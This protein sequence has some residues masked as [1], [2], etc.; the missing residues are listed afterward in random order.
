MAK[1]KIGAVMV[2]GG[3]I[4]GMQ[5]VLDL[6]E[7]GF[8][9]YLLEKSASIGGRMGQLDKT[10]PTNDCSMCIMGPKLVE[11]GRHLNIEI[12]TLSR[13]E[14][15]TG[16][17]GNFQVKVHQHSRYVDPDKCTGCGDCATVCPVSLPD[18]YNRNLSMRKA[19]YIMYPQSV[20][21]AYSIDKK[22]RPP[23]ISACPAHIN[24]QGYVAMI[25]AC[26]Y[27]EAIEIIMRDAP[28]PGTLGRVCVRFCEQECRRCE[29]DEPVSIKEL[30]RF[31]ADQ[32]DILSLPVPEVTAREE[33]VAIIGSGPSGL[34]A[35]YFLALDGFKPTIFEASKVPGGMLALGIPEYRLPRRILNNEIENIKRLG[36]EIKT[37]TPIGK[38]VTINDLL[39]GGY[40]AVYIAAGAHK[41]MKL[42]IH[43]ENRYENFQQSVPWFRGV[44]LGTIREARGKVVII[45]GGNAAIDAARVSLRLG[46]DEVHI[47]YRRTR[48]EMPADPLEIEDALQEGVQIHALVTPK[49]VIGDN[50]TLKGL[51]CLKNRL[52][53]P[54]SSGR[55]RPVPIDGSEFFIPA[56]QIIAAIGQTVDKSFAADLNEI[57]FTKND[58]L[59][60]NPYTLETTKKGVFAGGDVVTGP[61]TVIEAIAQGKKAAASI[62]S[63]LQDMWMPSFDG[64]DFQEKDY[65]PI[66]SS[67]PKMPRTQIPTLNATERIK[68]FQE[69]NLAMDE[70]TAQREAGRCLDCG[71]CCECFQCVEACKAQAIN[72]DMTDK[73]LDI[74]VGSIIIATGSEPYDPATNDT[75]QYNHF[76]NVVTSLEFE[77]I[78]SASGP[79]K[80]HLVRPSDK[81]EPK[82][83]AWIQC[84]GSRNIHTG[85]RG[86]CSSVC[87]TYAIKEAMIAKEHSSIPVDAAIFYIDVR[88][89]G[90]DFERYYNRAKEEMG[91]RFVKSR[92]NNILAGDEPGSLK[93]LYTDEAGRRVQEDFDIVVLSVGMDIHQDSIDLAN[94]L[95]IEL[96]HYNFVHTSSF[97]P[98]STSRAGIYVCGTLEAP[99]DIPDTVAQASAAAASATSALSEVRGTRVKTKEYPPE[100]DV[101]KEPIKIG[102]FI[103]HCGINIGGVA[104]VPAIVEYAKTLP[105]VEYAEDNLFSC[106]ED[107]QAKIKQV[108]MERGLNRLVVASCTP[109]TH[110]ALFRET[111]RE[112]GLNPYLFEMANIRDQC[113]WVHMQE[114]ERATEKAK[115][116]MHMAVAKAATLEQL[117]PVPQPVCPEALVV[118]GGVAGM[119][120]A[121]ELAEQ[122]FNACLI[123]RQDRLGGHAFRLHTTWKDES[124]QPYLEQMVKRVTDHPLIDV[125]LQTE[126]KEV[127]GIIGNFRSKLVNARGKETEVS[128]GAAIIANGAK[129]YEPEEYL[130][131]EDPNI[132]LSLD[133]DQEIMHNA[134]RLKEVNSAVFIQCVGSREPSRPYCS[135]VCCTHSIHS[136]LAL[137]QLNPDMDI[138]ILYRDIRTYGEREDLYREARSKGIHFIPYEIDDKPTVEKRGGKLK[139]I[140]TDQ[141][142]KMPVE[143]DSDIITLASAVVPQDDNGVLSKLFKVA[144]NQ[145]GFFMEAH[146]KLRPVDFS[147]AG[148]FVCGLAH[149]PKLIEGTISQAKAAASRAITVL[150]KDE[151]MAE[152]IVSSVNEDICAGCGICEQICSYAAIKVDIE[153]RVARVNEILCQGCG[154]CAAACP[155][156]AVQQRG[157]MREQMLS[158]TGAFLEGAS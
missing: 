68:T 121:L 67:E 107:T 157:F 117:Y 5:A 13:I 100:R 94:K 21:L 19:A 147:S 31:A 138:F 110:E 1:D 4:G 16:E 65:K 150:V 133:L 148:I 122:G 136:A 128:Y 28:L 101:S 120:A 137:K 30:K 135:K 113:T 124:V 7:S 59:N 81:K 29:V 45:G 46:A 109:R 149:S 143:I 25:K 39:K 9:V 106:S 99:K 15:I 44:N 103:C 86:Y 8:Y 17:E 60:V 139:V 93:I 126:I 27:K 151:V 153:T 158:M 71:A 108:I 85:D 47:A 80:G 129:S 66:D 52:G 74:D 24:V 141:V 49:T 155:S 34:S 23:C 56:D 10:F 90:K 79:Y 134:S 140:V 11:C 50:G 114:P 37:N 104:D 98:V 51:E 53:E 152:G 14:S 78:L 96:D 112:A 6:A 64:E 54:D 87:C 69:T 84:V 145:D 146:A 156:G 70:E 88:T 62:S 72:H 26:K 131:G 12:L 116:L 42:N 125:H 43:G 115:D 73:L 32:V 33:R 75:Y 127:D 57:G 132:L 82:K 91:I 77:R 123:E 3:G 105:H 58:L 2:V 142:I 144:T 41:G 35:A 38:D 95:G 89:Y 76:P 118:G 18:E 102:V 63:Y 83:I 111:C 154:A 36:V 130:Y 119:T 61:K 55:R 40:R 22:D 97:E 20:P 92:I 48:N